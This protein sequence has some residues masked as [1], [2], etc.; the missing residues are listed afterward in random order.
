[1]V[2]VSLLTHMVVMDNKFSQSIM[3]AL[4][5]DVLYYRPMTLQELKY[6]VAVADHLH[7]GRAA[8]ACHVTQPTLSAGLRCLEQELGRSLCERSPRGVVM[9]RGTA[10][11]IEQARQ[12]LNE[13]RR[14]NELADAGRL[15]LTGVLRLGAI[16]TV[17]PY[18]FPHVVAGLRQRWPALRLHL[19]EAR[20]ADLLRDLRRGELDAALLSPP[21]DAADLA[22]LPLYCEEF[23]LALPAGHR[24]L[25]R[26]R[27]TIADLAHEPLLLLDEGHCLRD[28]VVEF[29][30]IGDSAAREMLRSG[31]LETLRNMV[32]AGVGSTLLPALAVERPAAAP[33]ADGAMELRRLAAPA[34][35][36]EVGLYWRAGTADAESARLL[37]QSIVELLPAAVTPLG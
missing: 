8:A 37:A 10:S 20:T 29:C 33:P 2:A 30:R 21:L 25:A 7:F 11:L 4:A 12:V 35:E 5:I 34:P 23:Q 6:L 16:P 1:M 14:F 26:K 9:A 15:P 27:L 31:S 3:I 19:V 13:A 22:H 28:Q 17:G 36:R 24:L 18:L 32:A